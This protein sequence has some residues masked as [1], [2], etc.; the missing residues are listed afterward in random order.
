MLGYWSNRLTDAKK[1]MK[2]NQ[3]KAKCVTNP[4]QK[5]DQPKRSNPIQMPKRTSINDVKELENLN[6]LEQIVRDKRMFLTA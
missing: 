3:W 1:R 2:F 5:I 4:S 6:D